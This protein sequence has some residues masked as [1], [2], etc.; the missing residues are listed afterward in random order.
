MFGK[1]GF[2]Y[3]VSNYPHLFQKLNTLCVRKYLE[4]YLKNEV[5]ETI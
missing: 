1:L 4:I 3:I 5:F 2:L